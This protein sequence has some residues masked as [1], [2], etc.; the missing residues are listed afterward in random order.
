MKILNRAT[1]KDNFK[2][3]FYAFPAARDAFKEILM[4]PQLAQ[5]KI[6]MPAFIG[7]SDREGSGVFDPIRSTKI[8][9]EFY[10]MDQSLN[11]DVSDLKFRLSNNPNAILLLIHYWGFIDSSYDVVKKMA[12]D[13]G[14][15][16]I[17]DFAHGL[18]TFFNNPVIDFDYGFFS[19][20]KMFS[21]QGGGVLISRQAMPGLQEYNFKFFEFNLKAIAN[22]RVE[23]Y[24]FV[25]NKLKRLGN[26]HITILRDNVG[27]SV[28]QT[29]P[30]LLSSNK[31]KDEL[32]FK[33]NESG[34][35]VVSLYH[36]LIGEVGESYVNERMVSSRILNLPIHQDADFKSLEAMVER[37]AA[38]CNEYEG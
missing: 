38:I 28:P 10:K 23:N 15:T 12:K 20:H 11:I 17:E 33:L 26:K 27:Q 3:H 2:F 6:L 25:L 34:F 31:L 9:Y 4:Q 29:F 24:N 19:L 14:C 1:D 16:I 36:Q 21:Y 32:Y 30:I 37:M 18:F 35:G 5:K 13:Y 22:R 8:Q 7:Q